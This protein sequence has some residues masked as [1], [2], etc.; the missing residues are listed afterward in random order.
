MAPQLEE[1]FKERSAKFL[2]HE[3]TSKE[4]R[5]NRKACWPIRRTLLSTRGSFALKKPA[6]TMWE[7]GLTRRAVWPIK[8]A[9]RLTGRLCGLNIRNAHYHWASRVNM[10]YI[11]TSHD[12]YKYCLNIF[13]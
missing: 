6:P 7:M 2:A 11:I 12:T 13:Q 4:F 8:C 10:K 9:L 5:S 3:P 1:H